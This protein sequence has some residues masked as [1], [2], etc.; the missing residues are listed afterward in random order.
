MQGPKTVYITTNVLVNKKCNRVKAKE[1]FKQNQTQIKSKNL[2]TIINT[3]Q[4]SLYYNNPPAENHYKYCT[5]YIK[6]LSEDIR[7]PAKQTGS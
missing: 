6:L 2:K 5:N 7:E 3:L 4:N 1:S